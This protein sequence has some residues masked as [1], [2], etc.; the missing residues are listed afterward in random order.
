MTTPPPGQAGRGGACAGGSHA[1]QAPIRVPGGPNRLDIAFAHE[2][3][4]PKR[5]RNASS[6]AG[7][8]WVPS[9]WTT[10][11]PLSIPLIRIHGTSFTSI[12]RLNDTDSVAGDSRVRAMVP[13]MDTASVPRVMLN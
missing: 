3:D 9:A 6:S 13:C 7:D 4:S 11:T 8:S 12:G 5:S 1:V 10:V 2:T